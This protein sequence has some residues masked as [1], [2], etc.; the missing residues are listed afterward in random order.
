MS[1]IR[2][3]DVYAYKTAFELANFVWAIVRMWEPFSKQSL[4]M[5]FTEAADSISANLAEWF[6]RYNKRDKIKFYRYAQGSLTET[7]DWVQKALVRNLIT[8]EQHQQL[9]S[10]LAR[11]PREI[12]TL[13]RITNEKLTV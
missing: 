12:S 6:G 7:A 8:V 4:G 13:I 9:S 1:Y 5:Q 3:N 11:L 10:Y 2:F